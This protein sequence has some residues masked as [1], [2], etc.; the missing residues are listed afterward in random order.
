M[1]S[2]RDDRDVGAVRRAT[3][4]RFLDYWDDGLQV[5]GTGTKEMVWSCT[6]CVSP[7]K[8]L[9]KDVWTEFGSHI[10]HCHDEPHDE[11]AT[12]PAWHCYPV[13][14]EKV[15]KE[16]AEAKEAA[17]AKAAERSQASEKKKKKK[18]KELAPAIMEQ[19]APTTPLTLRT[20]VGAAASADGNALDAAIDTL[21]AAGY[22]ASI[23]DMA[24]I[25]A[26]IEAKLTAV[27]AAGPAAIVAEK[28]KGA[29][30]ARTPRF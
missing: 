18:E 8:V 10:V 16:K 2:D 27:P 23:H 21:I 15:R 20:C 26:A 11:V 17:V 28:E 24:C 22:T 1:K 3:A 13:W 25:A 7:K 5:D 12:T 4:A 19:P 30:R 29:K 14:T 9:K 6:I